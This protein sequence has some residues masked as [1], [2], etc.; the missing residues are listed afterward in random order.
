MTIWWCGKHEHGLTESG[1]CNDCNEEEEN[2][3]PD[4]GDRK[5]VTAIMTAPRKE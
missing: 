4:E 5:I 1:E 2:S 3:P